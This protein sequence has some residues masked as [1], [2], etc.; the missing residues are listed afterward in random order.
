MLDQTRTPSKGVTIRKSIDQS[1]KTH[2]YK[3][4]VN[5]EFRK[6]KLKS[7]YGFTGKKQRDRVFQIFGLKESVLEISKLINLSI[8]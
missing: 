2:P 5:L 3:M 4:T 1:D 6:V 8:K 7:T